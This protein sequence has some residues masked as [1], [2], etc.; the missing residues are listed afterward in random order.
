VIFIYSFQYIYY[1][2]IYIVFINIYYNFLYKLNHFCL[3]ELNI[4]LVNNF[5]DDKRIIYVE[6]TKIQQLLN[7]DC[8]ELKKE[9]DNI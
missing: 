1:F 9:L 3:F 8:I 7:N 4:I 2:I 6:F 5:E